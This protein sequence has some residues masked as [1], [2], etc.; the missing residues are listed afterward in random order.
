MYHSSK[1]AAIRG[2]LSNL[3]HVMSKSDHYF[4]HNLIAERNIEVWENTFVPSLCHLYRD[5][6]MIFMQDKY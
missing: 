3:I 1:E 4:F 5:Q 2:I 6:D